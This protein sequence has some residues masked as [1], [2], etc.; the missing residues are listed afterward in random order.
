MKKVI[1]TAAGLVI[2]A[3]FAAA[4]PVLGTWKTEVDDGNY[5]HV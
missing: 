2:G 3:G 5:A 1:G 4:D